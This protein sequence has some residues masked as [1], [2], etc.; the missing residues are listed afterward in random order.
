VVTNYTYDSADHLT[1]VNG[2]AVTSD[3]NGNVTQDDTGG[4]YSWDVR[5][6]L[7]G[8]TKNGS[9]YAF[10]YGPDNLR[11]AKTVNGVLTAYLLDGA[12]VVTDT[13]N[14]TANQTLYGPGTDHALARNGEF[15]LPNH[16]SSTAG[17]TNASGSLTQS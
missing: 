16:L 14:G 15:F 9:L 6:R 13:I 1:A 3:A 17:L 10:S 4:L 7:I 12:Q 11:L 2:N 5:G 8:L